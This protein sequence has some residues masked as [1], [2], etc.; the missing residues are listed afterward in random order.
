[1]KAPKPILAIGMADQMTMNDCHKLQA[2]LDKK[3]KGYYVLLYYKGKKNTEVEVFHAKDFKE[4][5]FADLKR[6]VLEQLKNANN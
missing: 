6:Q 4:I 5:E 3:Y 2:G 1:M